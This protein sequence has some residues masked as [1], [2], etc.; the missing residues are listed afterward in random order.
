MT[1]PYTPSTSEKSSLDVRDSRVEGYSTIPQDARANPSKDM[2]PHC[3][4]CHPVS[5]S[6]SKVPTY[7]LLCIV[8]IALGTVFAITAVATMASTQSTNTP[9]STSPNSVQAGLAANSRLRRSLVHR[10]F[11][12]GFGDNMML[13]V[14]LGGIAIA[15]LVGLS[16]GWV[17]QRRRDARDRV[18]RAC[19]GR[20]ERG[21]IRRAREGG[22]TGV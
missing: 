21:V 11:E 6:P 4:H 18:E 9:M 2:R 20:D 17:L 7:K 15:M 1:G 19:R 22:S 8:G 13:W 12:G 16:L 10:A 3:L 14:L 5:T